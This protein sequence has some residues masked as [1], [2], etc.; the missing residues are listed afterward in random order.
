MSAAGEDESRKPPAIAPG[1]ASPADDRRGPRAA[2]PA[3]PVAPAQ[4]RAELPPRREQA[5]TA[6]R[7]RRP[8]TGERML[9]VG[10]GTGVL[11]ERLLAEGASVLAVELDRGLEP[12]LRE[13]FARDGDRFDLIV[14]DVL[15]GK[16]AIHPDV[17]RSARRHAVPARRQ[18]A[19]PVATPL[20]AELATHH[21]NFTRG[22]AMVQREVA[23][24]LTAQPGTKQYG[25]LTVN[26]RAQCH[27]RRVMTLKPGCFFPPPAWTPPSSSSLA[28]KR[29]SPMTPTASRRSCTKSSPNAASSSGPSSAA[30]ATGPKASN[31]RCA[32][33]NST[34]L[35][36]RHWPRKRGNRQERQERPA[37][38]RGNRRFRR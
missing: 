12:L 35:H 1:Y 4:P 22:L 9:E 3:R 7:A 25:P 30:T 24:R 6:R 36:S 23:D 29:P 31:P 34:S 13:R 8:A 10:P 20:L 11:T 19:L 2:P 16:H 17:Q 28:A 15:A 27:V 14:T 37:T 32:P 18:P 21:R 5:P 26:I 38:P 33:N